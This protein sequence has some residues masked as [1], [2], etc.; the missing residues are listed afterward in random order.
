MN[1]KALLTLLVAML[2]Q[3]V[4]VG[5]IDG[6]AFPNMEGHLPFEDFDPERPNEG[7]FEMVDYAVKKAGVWLGTGSATHLA[8][9]E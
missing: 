9:P 1:R 5:E 7:Y 2:L 6:L 4:I 8:P 3:T